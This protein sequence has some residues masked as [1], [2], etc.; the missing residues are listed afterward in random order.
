MFL[1]IL[2]DSM[3][4]IDYSRHDVVIRFKAL[5]RYGEAGSGPEGQFSSFFGCYYSSGSFNEFL[6]AD[7]F[8]SI[9]LIIPGIERFQATKRH[10]FE[11]LFSWRHGCLAGISLSA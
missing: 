8:E 2:S 3:P 9:A 1:E 6:E 11:I 4:M 5:T 7:N 10:D